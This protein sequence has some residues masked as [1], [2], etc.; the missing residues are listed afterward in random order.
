MKYSLIQCAIWVSLSLLALTAC[1]SGTEPDENNRSLVVPNVVAAGSAN[2]SF[3]VN[4][5]DY[6]SGISEQAVLKLETTDSNG[7]CHEDDINGMT[8]DITNTVEGLCEYSYRILDIV[9]G[10]ET[11]SNSATLLVKAISGTKYPTETLTTIVGDQSRFSLALTGVLDPVVTVLG[12]ARAGVVSESEIFIN[13]EFAGYSRIIYTTE[14]DNGGKGIGE[15]SL[16]TASYTGTNMYWN[17]QG[18]SLDAPEKEKTFDISSDTNAK[19][20][21]SAFNSDP[22]VTVTIDHNNPLSLMVEKANPY[23]EV[24]SDLTVLLSDHRGKYKLVSTPFTSF[25]HP[26]LYDKANIVETDNVYLTTPPRESDALQIEGVEWQICNPNYLEGFN[27]PLINKD[28]HTELACL[29]LNDTTSYTNYCEALDIM[30]PS[31]NGAE[32]DGVTTIANARLRSSE[33]ASWVSQAQYDHDIPRS[34]FA[35]QVVASSDQH[36]MHAQMNEVGPQIYGII[37]VGVEEVLP[38][39]N[40]VVLIIMNEV[41]RISVVPWITSNPAESTIK[42]VCIVDK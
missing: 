25:G 4:M 38:P 27:I 10:E 18:L 23:G 28:L 17:T 16:A 9:E 14:E 24:D 29:S 20:I 5:T 30:L 36:R 37:S 8:V 32:W 35:L 41:P 34:M 15:I 1:Q 19:Q 22:N 6:I 33:I 11:I 2:D 12:T 7:N 40:N 31:P 42:P 21:V 13:S 26:S 3:K 39:N